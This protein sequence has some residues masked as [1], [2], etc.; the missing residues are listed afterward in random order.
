MIVYRPSDRIPIQIGDALIYVAPLSYEQKVKLL[1]LTKVL[2]GE[3][4]TPGLKY[5]L[6]LLRECV[7]SVKN[8]FLSDG[9]E[10]ELSFEPD[11]RLTAGCAEDLLLI[12]GADRLLVAVGKLVNEGI[13]NHKIEGVKILLDKVSNVKK[14]S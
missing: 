6:E 9:S 4:Q 10:W 5:A 3:E 8:I 14:K 1:T 13:S 2:G 7:K 11:G 12:G